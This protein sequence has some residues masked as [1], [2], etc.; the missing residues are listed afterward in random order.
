MIGVVTCLAYS[1]TIDASFHFD[2]QDSILTNSA[3]RSLGNF[4][5]L[6]SNWAKR[7]VTYLSFALNYHFFGLGVRSFHVVNIALHIG[8]GILVWWLI[9]LTAAA[10]S[11][12]GQPWTTM[13][14]IPLLAGLLFALHPVQTQAV[15]YIVQ[16]AALL[17]TFFYLL[18]ACFYI[19][20]RLVQLTTGSF[21]RGL[22][23]FAVCALMAFIGMFSKEIVYT[24]PIALVLY[25]VFFLGGV[26]GLNWRFVGAIGAA[27]ALAIV[28]LIYGGLMEL[29]DTTTISRSLYSAT[30]LK[31]LLIYVRLLFLPIHQSLEYVVSPPMEL[32]DIEMLAGLA[33]LGIMIIASITMSKHHRL[34]SFGIAWFVVTLLPESSIIPLK[35]FIFEHRLYL[36]MVGFVFA[37]AGCAIALDK[38]LPRS[39]KVIGLATLISLSGVMAFE[40]NKVWK[41]DLSLW[42]DVIEK[43]PTKARAYVNRARAFT[44]LKEYEL[45]HADLDRAS[46]LDPTLVEI[47]A[48]R[49]SI[50]LILGDFDA[51]IAD[52]GKAIGLGTNSSIAL[53]RIFYSRGS[54]FLMK[55]ELDSA[56]A[57]L[58]SAVSNDPTYAEAYNNRGYAYWLKKESENAVREFTSAL[59]CNPRY[60]KALTNRAIAFIDLK[61]PRDAVADLD[62]AI[63]LQPD[64]VDAFVQRA[65]ANSILG[66]I[67]KAHADS[68]AALRLSAERRRF[69]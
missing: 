53:S 68:A 44:D 45:A 69:P 55:R 61:R 27:F 1:N 65:R 41:N 58:S 67:V 38:Y 66:D 28:G 11:M 25:D 32:L 20:G 36:P 29:V 9:R 7:F 59:R 15:T 62:G 63:A 18:T 14:S 16:R 37:T 52:C 4:G 46:R 31:V 57:D 30:Q 48:N 23:W 13:R 8:N 51:T 10:P 34:I 50:N 54:A 56:L 3:I 17:G 40:R 49:A 6:W 2:D 19:K 21:M 35:D 26:R 43:A 42:S 5:E 22:G 64:N 33:V 47:Y 39:V 60:G 12:K 24:L